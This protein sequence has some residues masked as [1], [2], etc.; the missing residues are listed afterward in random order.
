MQLSSTKHQRLLVYFEKLNFNVRVFNFKFDLFFKQQRLGNDSKKD[1]NLKFYSNK[2]RINDG[3]NIEEFQT[4]YQNNFDFLENKPD[5]M[6]WLFPT[7]L[8]GLNDMIHPLQLHELEV[9][10]L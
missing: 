10:F 6:Q 5:Y 9:N 1:L 4:K 8:Q 3:L 2:H 7:Y